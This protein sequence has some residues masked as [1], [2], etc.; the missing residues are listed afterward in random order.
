MK[1]SK[2][3]LLSR[4]LPD[5]RLY[6]LLSKIGKAIGQVNHLFEKGVKP[7]EFSFKGMLVTNHKIANELLRFSILRSGR[8]LQIDR[9]FNIQNSLYCY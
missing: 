3:S 1:H 7:L 4:L 2:R 5:V 8:A 6:F 9:P